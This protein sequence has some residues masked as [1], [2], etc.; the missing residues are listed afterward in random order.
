METIDIGANSSSSV[1]C[2]GELGNTAC[3]WLLKLLLSVAIYC[4][5]PLPIVVQ[6]QTMVAGNKNNIG[7][8]GTGSVLA[9]ATFFVSSIANANRNESIKR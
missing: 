8:Q 1:A 3:N 9:T 6:G 7:A 4:Y 5:C 2:T